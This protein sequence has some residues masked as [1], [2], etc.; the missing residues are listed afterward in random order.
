[1]RTGI[2]RNHNGT[3]I[4]LIALTVLVVLSPVHADESPAKTDQNPG[5]T[6]T[7]ATADATAPA[8]MAVRLVY[9]FQPGQFIHYSG[10]SKVQYYT[11]LDEKTF[12]SSQ[13]NETSTHIRVVTVDEQGVATIEPVLDRARMTAQMPDKKPVVFDSRTDDNSQPQFQAVRDSIGKSVARFQVSPAGKLVK[14]V[15]VESSAPK[16]LQDAAERLETRFPF[17]LVLPA[18][19]ISVGDKWREEYSVVIVNEGLKQ[20]VPLRRIY[21]LNSVA[22]GIARIKFRTLVLTPLNDPEL[23]KQILQQTPS[24]TIEF[25]IERGLVR[26]YVANINRTSHNAFGPRTLLQ[27]TGESTEKLVTES[28]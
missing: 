15:I 13:T 8:S 12:P 21:E 5:V 1:M 25:D 17:L 3:G 24:G 23:E 27:V 9:K 4:L 10:S 14:A 19:A 20:P 2:P 18:T 7:S 11:Q 26:S 16:A 28:K 22:D 6:Q